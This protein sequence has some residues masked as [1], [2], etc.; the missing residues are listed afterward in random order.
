MFVFGLSTIPIAYI[1]SFRFKKPSSGFVFMVIAF[2]LFGFLLNLFLSIIDLLRNFIGMD[3][4]LGD[5]YERIL[6]VARIVPIFSFLFGYQKVYKLTTFG[7]ICGQF[8]PK[9]LEGLCQ[10]IDI[11][12]NTLQVL[13]GCCEDCDPCYNNV[14]PFAFDKYGAGFEIL[15]M[16]LCGLLCF[17][18]ILLYEGMFYFRLFS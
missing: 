4:I 9:T 14:K 13:K 3:Y 11:G 16:V 6:D 10:L 18:A 17:A 7:K 5:W 8:P 1:L 15:Y 12:D 2:F